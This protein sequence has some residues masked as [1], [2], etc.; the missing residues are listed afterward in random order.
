MSNTVLTGVFFAFLTCA[1]PAIH[2]VDAS[3]RFGVTNL[4]QNGM[5]GF[6]KS[7]KCNDICRALG[8]AET[9][10]TPSSVGGAGGGGSGSASST[11]F[12]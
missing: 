4:K 2:C 10:P 5:D 6:F 8:L 1:D 11:A 7:H 3:H 9:R 12:L